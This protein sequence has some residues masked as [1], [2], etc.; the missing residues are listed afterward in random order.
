M[1]IAYYDESGDDGYPAY[2]SPLFALSVTY[3]HHLNWQ[4]T[5]QRLREFRSYLK[6][7]FGLPIKEEF[8][9]KG[10]LLNKNPYRNL[11]LQEDQ[12]ESV[13]DQY[14]L[15]VGNLDIKIINVVIVKPKINYPKYQVLDTALKYS[16]QR[17]ENDLDPTHNP[18]ER[19]L[20]ITDSGRV[21]KMQSTTRRIQ[22]INYIP[23]KFGPAYRSEIRTMIEDPLPKDSRE[24]YFIQVSD[25]VAYVVYLY[26]MFLYLPTQVHSR[27][28][29]FVTNAKVISWLELLKP[30]LNLMASSKDSYGILFHP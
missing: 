24:S 20:M 21:G 7:N 6:D 25:L 29:T 19:F 17:I 28:P 30:S 23:S 8:H 2:S 9:T 14:C 5:F 10:F 22:K 27:L 15:L 3:L 1:R 13:L 11:N 26:G 12:R 18:N 16:I 4:P